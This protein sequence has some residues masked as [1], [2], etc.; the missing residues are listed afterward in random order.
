MPNIGLRIRELRQQR[1]QT[2]EQVAAETGLSVSFISMLERDKVSISV[3]NLEKLANYFQVHMVHFF[4]SENASPVQITRREEILKSL[5][6]TGKGPAAVT[7]LSNRPDARMEPLLVTIAPGKEEPHFREHQADVLLYVLEGDAVLLSETG[8]EI[9]LHQGD[10]AYY[11]NVPH[12]RLSNPN[13]KKHLLLIAITSPQTSSL[14]D[15]VQAR[16][17][18]WLMSEKK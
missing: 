5:A 3:D 9:E 18:A 15:L 4:R 16:Q 6:L 8:E 17:G 1:G 14:D 11:V 13:K 7:L 10:M 12:R 2:L